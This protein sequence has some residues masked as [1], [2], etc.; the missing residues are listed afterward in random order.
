LRDVFADR[1][2]LALL[3]AGLALRALLTIALD[4]RLVP[5]GDEGTY[6]P[7]AGLLLHRGVLETGFLERPPLYF[8]SVAVAQ[9]LPAPWAS[10]TLTLRLLQCLAGVATALPVY[11]TV[12]RSA[13]RRAARLAVA[14]LL[15]DPTLVGFSHLIWP[16][17]FFTCLAAFVYDGVADLRAGDSRRNFAMGVLVGAALLIRPAF[18]IFCLVL[19]GSWLVRLGPR[20]AARLV[21]VVGGTAA[22]VISPWVLR[23]QLRYGPSI[24]LENEGP[25]NLW[26]GNAAE[27][28]Q[29]VNDAWRTLPDPVT[30]GRVGTERGMAAIRDDPDEFLRRSVSRFVNVWGLE[31][32]VVRHLAIGGYPNVSPGGFLIAFWLIQLAWAAQLLCAAAGA[33]R[34]ARDPLL[35]LVLLNVALFTLLVTGLVG[36]TRFRVA[37]AFGLC[38]CAGIGLDRLLARRLTR[39]DLAAVLAA[40]LLLGASAT[41]PLFRKAIAGDFEQV[42][43]LGVAPWRHFRY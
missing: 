22:L 33:R 36:T 8:V 4:A 17:T 29:E 5:Q 10:D 1:W 3:G 39:G 28:V 37:F 19:A 6:L 30:R 23:N 38:A 34:A 20:A 12:L 43:E 21:L 16:E 42:A 13:G 31:Y 40:T 41:K 27:S 32:F 15:F 11:R 9:W 24:L 18:G 25:Y 26:A 2:A 7:Y 14:F 35:G